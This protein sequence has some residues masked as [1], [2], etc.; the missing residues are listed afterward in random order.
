MREPGTQTLLLMRADNLKAVLVPQGTGASRLVFTLSS[1]WGCGA[2][3]AVA[4]GLLRAEAAGKCQTSVHRTPPW[5][6]T[7]PQFWETLH[8]HFVP[9]R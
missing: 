5:P 8:D 1:T 2:A 7:G 4:Q 3:A 6:Q 9:Q